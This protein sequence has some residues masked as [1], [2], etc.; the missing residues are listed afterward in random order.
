[1]LCGVWT[2][3]SVGKIG[4]HNESLFRGVSQQL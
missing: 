3:F 2:F 4:V 1:V